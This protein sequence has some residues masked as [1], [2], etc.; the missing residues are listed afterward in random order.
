M[1]KLMVLIALS[2]LAT[3]ANAAWTTRNVTDEFSG[4]AVY[5][6]VAGNPQRPVGM[7][8]CLN[9]NVALGLHARDYLAN[10]SNVRMDW[11]VGEHT[12]WI[13]GLGNGKMFISYT[14]PKSLIDNMKAGNELVI[15][16]WNYNGDSH[17]R[18][19]NL[20]GFTKTYN[21]VKSTCS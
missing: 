14:P 6:G 5:T 19:F 2:T 11:R 21:S 9:G 15:K 1:K 12:D 18:K 20:T 3:A 10:K 17:V 8:L 13:T 4:K 16:F 7:L